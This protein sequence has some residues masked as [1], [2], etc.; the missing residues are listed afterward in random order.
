MIVILRVVRAF[1]SLGILVCFFSG[2]RLQFAAARLARWQKFLTNAI[3]RREDD[4]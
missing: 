1:L 2:V 4:A 3:A